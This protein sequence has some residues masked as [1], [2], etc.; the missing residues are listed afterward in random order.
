MSI[1]RRHFLAL[2]SAALAAPALLRH[3]NAQQPAS[4]PQASAQPPANAPQPIVFKLHHFLSP[5]AYAHSRVLVPWAKAIEKESG[6]R[7]RIDLFPSMQLGG[8]APQL[9]D[10]VVSGQADIVLT[11]PG[12]T[13]GRFPRIEVFEL[14]FVAD[15]RA[16]VNSRAVQQL[17][18]T[19]LRD[20]FKEVQTICVGAHD[21]GVLHTVKPVTKL[22]DLKNMKLRAPTRLA[23]EALKA[24][25]ANGITLPILQIPDALSQ[26]AIDGALIPWEVVPA[27]KLQEKVKFH[28]EIAGSPTL[29]TATFIVAMN[30]QRYDKLPPD[31]KKIVDSHSGQN[32]AQMAG[33][34]WD[35]LSPG[36]EETARKQGNTITQLDKTESAR[37]MKA[38]QPV[39]DTWIKELKQRKVDGG[40]LLNE[41]KAA[42]AKFAG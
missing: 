27:I 5:V 33:K 40:A 39:V 34:M 32:A 37:W 24:L 10:Q 18:E 21:Q 15:R 31:L 3:A 29:Y 14:P 22:E 20:E 9:Y 12:L 26:K 2:G 8:T 41:A 11:L 6:G 38:T 35:D 30:K 16:V 4:P 36:V 1:G 17:Y 25:G 42:I 28:T 19:R 7:I 23:S 13:P